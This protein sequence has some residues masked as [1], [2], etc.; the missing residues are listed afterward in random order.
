MAEKQD[1]PREKKQVFDNDKV[2]ALA[3]QYKRNRDTVT[4]QKICAESNN[5][6]DAII[7]S[8]RYD[9]KVPFGDLKNH[10]FLQIENWI[11]KWV[12]GAGKIYTYFTTC[13]RNGCL[14]Y[15][16]KERLFTE[17][18]AVTDVP[19]DTIGEGQTHTPK[20]ESDVREVLEK[21]LEDINCRWQEPVIREVVRYLVSCVLRNRGDRR[22][23]ILRTVVLGWPVQIETAKFLLDWT[24]GA[25]R[26]ALLEHFHQPLGEI[27]VYRAAQKFGFLP[28]LINTVGIN[29][30][31]QMMNVFAGTSIRFPSLQQVR[32]WHEAVRIFEEMSEDPSP[33]NIK[34]LAKRY[35][36]S[37]AKVQEAFDMVAEN[38][39][40]GVLEDFPLYTDAS[41]FPKL[42]KG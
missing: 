6:M 18:F 26:M 29:A 41:Q 32:R 34:R 10:L 25:V 7:R 2:E 38:L 1:P 9:R 3:L 22:P 28:D 23:Q 36:R 15:L 30:T 33:E 19:L 13:I 42:D 11:L 35:R 17:R 12:P 27:D 39:Q 24:H 37:P 5:L 21:V 40:A 20:F 14:S 16:S 8:K 4:Y 31:K